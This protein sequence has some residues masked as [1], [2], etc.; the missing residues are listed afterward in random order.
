MTQSS[1][2][3]N[4]ITGMTECRIK[5]LI[6]YAEDM[7]ARERPVPEASSYFRAHAVTVYLAWC[8]VTNGFHTVE[9]M[10][11]LETLTHSNTLAVGLS[12]F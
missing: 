9:D 12:D 4:V 1:S 11:R 10:N 8:D 2:F 3:Y 7:D 6:H 5:E